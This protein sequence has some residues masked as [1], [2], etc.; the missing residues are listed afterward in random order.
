MS[1]MATSPAIVLHLV[2]VKGADGASFPNLVLHEG[3]H[4]MGRAEDND[5]VL[6]AP[7]VAAYHCRIGVQ[8]G[9][10]EVTRLDGNAA[11]SLNGKPVAGGKAMPV[12]SGDR[13]TLGTRAYK[14]Q[15]EKR[16]NTTVRPAPR[17]MTGGGILG[18]P[19]SLPKVGEEFAGAR[20]E[21]IL[22]TGGTA[23]VFRAIR[24][25][26]NRTVAIKVLLPGQ[27]FSAGAALRFYREA[28][29]GGMLAAHPVAVAIVEIGR[30]DP[31]S[32][33]A[34]E[35]VDGVDVQKILD[36]EK[37]L[38]PAVALDII[39]PVADLLRFAHGHQL[40]HRDIKPSNIMVCRDG[41]VKLLDLGL[42][43]EEGRKDNYDL[44]QPQQGFGTLHFV[45]P[46]QAFDAASVDF[47]ADIYALGATLF[48]MVAGRPPIQVQ[49]PAEFL[50]TLVKTGA[51]NLKTIDPTMPDGLCN[52]LARCL[53]MNRDERYGKY[54]DLIRDLT[55]V[56]EQVS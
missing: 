28:M 2:P 53:K 36:K 35:F 17:A 33:I 11:L 1:D 52:A 50:T 22:G 25:D 38:P 4:R 13:L 21:G 26:N 32:Y 3:V 54:E 51:P 44:T 48:S 9:K 47:R 8:N 56:R 49:S 16:Q 10:V 23:V 40:I 18:G 43:R 6:A 7:G 14:M 29:V 15:I 20:L 37:K 30:C 27:D 31:F 41:A 42:A 12:L 5:F 45:A 46:E 34:M 39:L 55:A 24:L 19:V